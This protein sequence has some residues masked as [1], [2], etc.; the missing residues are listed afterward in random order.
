MTALYNTIQQTSRREFLWRV[1]GGLGG[2]ALA[3]L[4]G[5]EN[6]FA[7][8][9]GNPSL[10][11]TTARATVSADIIFFLGAFGQSEFQIAVSV[12]PGIRAITRMPFGRNSSR[13]VLV[14]P[15]APCFDAL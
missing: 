9:D 5:G 12:A 10:A 8:G 2:I 6:L 1:G 14:N 3:H 11:L 4:L 15:S 7:D 13:R